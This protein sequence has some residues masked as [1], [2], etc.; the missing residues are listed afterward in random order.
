MD[1]EEFNKLDATVF[2]DY[3]KVGKKADSI[4]TLLKY[5]KR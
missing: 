2:E 5:L 1:M 4:V 3:I